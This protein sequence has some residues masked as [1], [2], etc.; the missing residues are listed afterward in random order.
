[1]PMSA[2]T[3]EREL[4]ADLSAEALALFR[5][6]ESLHRS[7]LYDPAAQQYEALLA[8]VG[9]HPAV[10]A[11]HWNL[12]DCYHHLRRFEEALGQYDL[13][14][15]LRPGDPEILADRGLSLAGLGR[16]AEAVESFQAALQRRPEE[17]RYRHFLAFGLY[18][19]GRR[20]EASEH[21]LQLPDLPHAGAARAA[22]GL[23]E[24]GRASEAEACLGRARRGL[25]DAQAEDW[26]EVG[27]VLA[28]GGQTS[29]A[30]RFLQEALARGASHEVRQAVV[31]FLEGAFPTD[32]WE[33]ARRTCLGEWPEDYEAQNT[34]A[35]DS[36][37]RHLAYVQGDRLWVD[38]QVHPLNASE[39]DGLTVSCRGDWAVS[40]ERGGEW[41]ALGPQRQYGPFA[42][43]PFLK[44]GADGR[45]AVV[46]ADQVLLDGQPGPKVEAV[47]TF[48]FSR[49]G[50]RHAYL[51]ADAEGQH[52]VL[53]GRPQPTCPAISRDWFDFSPD[54][55]RF[56]FVA[57]EGD[58]Q[59]VVLDGLAGEVYDGVAGLVFS[60][61]GRHLVHWAERDGRCCAVLDGQEQGWFEEL[62][63]FTLDQAGTRF[64][65]YALIDGSKHLLDNGKRSQPYEDVYNVCLSPDGASCACFAER[66]GR[67]HCLVDGVE[68]PPWEDVGTGTLVWNAVRRCW[69][70][71]AMNDRYQWV[72]VVAGRPGRACDQ[73]AT[74][75]PVVTPAGQVACGLC[76]DGAW[77]LS[78]DGRE[79]PPFDQLMTSPRMDGT[80]IG[81]L[82]VADG[83][84]YRLEIEADR[85]PVA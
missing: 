73:F 59:R 50:S 38:G 43:P 16:M 42:E 63:G 74:G 45:L 78:V 80:T 39:V 71:T 49:D 79:S 36:L 65:C 26:A 77:F 64:A 66:D 4:G 52:V 9:D 75:A 8:R 28:S 40:V 85:F 47:L 24:A 54:G 51:A 70:Y 6:S 82:V 19:L 44:F 53:D 35:V 18:D 1:M 48:R 41:F 68:S 33:A 76:R 72:A 12:G 81:S 58:R 13:A 30:Q 56:A 10:L 14:L 3:L 27:L 69:C 31:E 32:P 62:G 25:Q 17:P 23:L 5:T 20:A 11:L 60:G 61:D 21:L 55:S 34:L 29:A 84:V 57:Q 15:A 83:S 7:G 67:W 46:T 22:V 37:G 2:D